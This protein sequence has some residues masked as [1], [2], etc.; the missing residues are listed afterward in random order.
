MDLPEIEHIDPVGRRRHE[1]RVP[2]FSKGRVIIH[3][4]PLTGV[5]V[6]GVETMVVEDHESRVDSTPAREG[7]GVKTPHLIFAR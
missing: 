5:R 2:P 1:P 3:S 6:D 7:E 4:R